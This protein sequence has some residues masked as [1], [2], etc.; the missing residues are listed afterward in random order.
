MGTVSQPWRMENGATATENSTAVL[1]K[2]KTRIMTQ[3]FPLWV[4][5][6]K[7]PEGSDSN[8]YLHTHAVHVCVTNSNIIHNKTR[9]QGECALQQRQDRCGHKD[10]QHSMQ[11]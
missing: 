1:P 5:L 6:F 7:R 2:G 3:Q 8:T 10:P 9:K 4:R 11:A